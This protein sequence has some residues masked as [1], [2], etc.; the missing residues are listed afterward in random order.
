VFEFKLPDLGEGVHEGEILKWY[1]EVGQTVKEDEPLVDVETDKAAVTI[2]SPRGGKLVRVAG[3]VGDTVM[4]GAV[5]A[6]IDEAGEAG[7]T[8]AQAPAAPPRSEPPPPPRAP[9]AGA[10]AKATPAP[11]PVASRPTAPAPA[12]APAHATGAATTAVARSSN[13]PVPAAPAT[14]RVARELGIDLTQVPGSGPGGRVTTEDVRIFAEGG[15]AVAPAVE[16]GGRAPSSVA[17]PSGIPFFEL[18]PMPSFEQWGPVERQSV[19]SIRRKVARKMVTSMVT[20]PHVAHMD[21][22]DVT[23]LEAHR[24]RMKTEGGSSL[25]LMAFV[26]RAV[27]VALKTYKSFNASLDPERNELVYKQFYNIGFAAD[28]PRGLLVPV[29]KNADQQTIVGI[30]DEI[31]RLASAAREGTIGVTDLQGGTFTVT[32]VGAIGGSYVVP[33]I[34]Y[35]ESAILGMGRVQERAVVRQGT[36]VARKILPLCITF[37]H[38][39]SDGADGARFMNA[40][41]RYLSDP[42]SLLSEM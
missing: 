32:N 3:G 7:A 34:N 15:I 22:A 41:V 28:T 33:T 16:L 14:R 21:D 35:P 12:K 17:V 27:T 19:V 13:G 5:L 8:S 29:I 37:D 2:P 25:T 18:E 26:V 9:V 30:S 23:E 10:P 40:L 1:V 6:A 20:V 38:R 24:V 36:I 42:L 4:V 11:P 39:I 31:R